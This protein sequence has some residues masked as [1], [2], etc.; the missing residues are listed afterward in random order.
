MKCA[1]RPVRRK[2]WLHLLLAGSVFASACNGCRPSK[3]AETQKPT[4]RLYLVSNMAGALEPCGCV[5]DQLGGLDHVA[6]LMTQEKKNAPNAAFVSA[7][8]TFFL[9]PVI[10]EERKSQ[11][12]AKAETIAD[13]IKGLD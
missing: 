11:E 4:I 7:G 3:N 2:A 6:A 8:P 13:V 1:V 10:K 12:H 5:K 9:D